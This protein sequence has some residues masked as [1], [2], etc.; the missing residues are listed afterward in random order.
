MQFEE[1]EQVSSEEEDVVE[2]KEDDDRPTI[3]NPLKIPLGFDG[4][5][6]PYWLYKLHGL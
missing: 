6:I 1:E 2:D 5:P 4:K 3:K